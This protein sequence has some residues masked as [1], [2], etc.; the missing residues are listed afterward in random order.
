MM[1]W[2]PVIGYEN[3]YAVSRTGAVMRTGGGSGSHP[4]RILNQ[5]L[6][7]AGYLMVSLY[8]N[9]HRR[10]M[11][12]HTLVA[13]AFVGP[14]PIGMDVNH[15]DGDKRNNHA[16]NLEYMSRADNMRHARDIGLIGQRT[17][18]YVPRSHCLRGHE[19][20]PENTHVESNGARRCRVCE[21]V[22]CRAYQ[23]RRRL[24]QCA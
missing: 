3:A 24:R 11:N 13:A 17:A 14:R 7:N 20:T 22:K 6:G 2:R 21:R 15:K 9:G 5:R 8:L 16:S 18:T 12:V 4:G 1:D 23:E 19:F 10:M